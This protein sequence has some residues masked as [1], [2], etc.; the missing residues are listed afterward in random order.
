MG[1]IMLKNF[2]TLAVTL[3]TCSAAA[4]FSTST[5]ES[6]RAASAVQ[7]NKQLAS[8]LNLTKDADANIISFHVNG[9]TSD[10]ARILLNQDPAP[11]SSEYTVIT[12]KNRE[13]GSCCFM[14]PSTVATASV[15]ESI[16][17]DLVNAGSINIDIT[18]QKTGKH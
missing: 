12:G 9:I 15:V 7:Q 2:F 5:T 16:S 3:A 11:L 13:G 6:M 8:S 18:K 14:L 1:G 17:K 4:A 10:D